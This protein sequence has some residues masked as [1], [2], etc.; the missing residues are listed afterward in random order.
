[1]LQGKESR[2]GGALHM[3]TLSMIIFGTIGIFRRMIP[4]PSDVLAF[5]RG[6][7][8][9]VFLLLVLRVR[10]GRFHREQ[11]HRKEFLLLVL[12]GGMIGFNWILLFEAYNYTTVAVAT[13]CY[14]M[15]PVIVTALSPLVLREKLTRRQLLCVAVSVAGM[16]L[17]SGVTGGAGAAETAAAV[18]SSGASGA[19]GTAGAAGAAGAFLTGHSRG[20][21]LGL[22]A[23]VLYACVVLLNKRITGVPPFEKTIVQLFSAA[24]VLIPY[25]AV[26]GTLHAWALP[27]AAA[28]LF[29]TA[30]I[31]HT[32]VAYILYF[33]A[34][35]SLPARTCALLSYIDPVTA[36]ILSAVLLHEPMNAAGVIGT[37][38]I[39]GAAVF[40]ELGQG[41]P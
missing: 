20:V 22:G 6:I 13:L 14:Y 32:G 38:L 16:I 11:I 17:V 34:V 36:V 21:L 28:V 23:A 5:G 8:G 18:S 41:K 33:R 10:G 9:G 19:I 7:M 15:Q 1:M 3:L 40:S 27:A 39:I 26:Q 37:V 29:V 4:L 2:N 30:G 25:M 35:E 24:F 12:T 31:V